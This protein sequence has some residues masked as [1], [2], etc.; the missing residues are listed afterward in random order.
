[1]IFTYYTYLTSHILKTKSNILYSHTLLHLI[2]ATFYIV[3]CIDYYTGSTPEQILS[4]YPIEWMIMTPIMLV[5]LSS[6]KKVTIFTY[7]ILSFLTIMMNFLGYVSIRF[8][9]FNNT[10]FIYTFFSLGMLCFVIILGMLYA[11]LKYNENVAE[12]AEQYNVLNNNK[13]YKVLL[14]GVVCSWSAYPI[15]YILYLVS[16]INTEICMIAFAITDLVSKIAFTSIVIGYELYK[17]K[18]MSP[19]SRIT[20]RVARIQPLTFPSD[21]AEPGEA[22]YTLSDV[23]QITHTATMAAETI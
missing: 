9:L 19:L 18:I 20:T 22:S 12:N 10:I 2:P 23:P 3:V 7:Y 11:I 4:L 1:M 13:I 17:H 16:Y 15:I 6:I 5:T 14:L 8:I 21:Q